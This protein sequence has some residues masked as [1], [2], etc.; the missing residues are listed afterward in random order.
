MYFFIGKV[1]G[2]VAGPE[3]PMDGLGPGPEVSVAGAEEFAGPAPSGKEGLPVLESGEDFIGSRV[4]P[5]F[6]E[7]PFLYIAK[8]NVTGKLVG[9]DKAFGINLPKGDAGTV[10]PV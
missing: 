10:P 4:L 8:G 3:A 1:A 2:R 7:G 6:P 9:M 5:D